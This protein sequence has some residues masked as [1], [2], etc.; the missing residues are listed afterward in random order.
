MARALT[1]MMVSLLAAPATF[2]QTAAPTEE[3]IRPVMERVLGYLQTATPLRPINGDTGA[4]VS[5][6]NMPRNVALGRTDIRINTYEAGVIYAGMLRATTVTGDQRYRNYVN[7][8]LSG[9]ARM[10]AHMRANYPTATYATYPSS[11]ASGSVTLRRVLFP[12]NLDDFSHGGVSLE[13]RDC[14]LHHPAYGPGVVERVALPLAGDGFGRR[15]EGTLARRVVERRQDVLSKA[16][17]EHQE[18]LDDLVPGQRAELQRGADRGTR[19]DLVGEVGSLRH[20]LSP[21]PKSA[22]RAGRAACLPRRRGARRAS[23][24]AGARTPAT[25]PRAAGTTRSS[26]DG[27]SAWPPAGSAV[28]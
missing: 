4:A 18:R 13:R 6:D 9:I 5:L 12:Q 17:V 27:P 15:R 21:P 26:T 7:T 23:R 22:S 14:R 10:A 20:A 3:S 2:A 11:V 28:R 25:M 19:L 1:L 24:S 16:R 8:R